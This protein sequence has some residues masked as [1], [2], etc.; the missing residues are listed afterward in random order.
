M[1]FGFTEMLIAGLTLLSSTAGLKWFR[2]EKEV[3]NKVKKDTIDAIPIL[4]QFGLQELADLLADFATGNRLVLAGKVVDKVR[5][6]GRA[7]DLVERLKKCF[8]KM[9]VHLLN[10]PIERQK[11]IEAV[12]P[13]IKPAVE[14][15]KVIETTTAA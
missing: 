14:A 15:A 3:V 5:E 10:D 11:I 12:S 7:G 2:S 1:S 4:H 13:H 6:I 9:M 8:Y